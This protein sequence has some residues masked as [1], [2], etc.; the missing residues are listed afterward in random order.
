MK[1][2]LLSG[3]AAA[4]MFA[5]APVLAADMPVK[6]P[7]PVAAAYN[8]QGCYIGVQ[9]GGDW[10]R[11]RHDGFPPG[12]TDLT[13]YFRL[14]GGEAGVEYGC[15]YNLGPGW[16]IGTESDFSWTDKKGSSFDTGAG[17]NPTFLSTTQERWNST[18]RLR[19]GHTWDRT[20][21][22]ATGGVA[23]A[24]VEANVTVPGIGI[25]SDSHTQ[26]GWVAGVGAEYAFA[27]NWSAKLE[28]LHMDFSNKSFLFGNNPVLVGLNA[29]RS[30]LNLTDDLVRVGINYRFINCLLFCS[31]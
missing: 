11:S 21:V 12:P 17:G 5:S 8:W 27:P 1:S 28:Y 24:R 19:L 31:R 14:S 6:A 16:L 7:I 2:I 4:A 25:F 20:L 15:N 3:L 18:T 29:Q 22:Y 9:G 23:A 26:W 10:G 30:G 13:P